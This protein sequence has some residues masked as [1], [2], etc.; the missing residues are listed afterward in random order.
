[1]KPPTIKRASLIL[2]L[3]ALGATTLA[4][5]HPA[6]EDAHAQPA[7]AAPATDPAEQS[8]LQAFY[9]QKPTWTPCGEL[10]CATLTVP[11]DY[12]H[13][14]NGQTFTLPLAK[15]AAADPAQ[16][17][18]SLAFNPGGPGE[19]GV[20]QLKDG[21]LSSFSERTRAR[22]DIVGFDPRGVAG[23]KPA[24]DC[25]S[26]DSPD[27]TDQVQPASDDTSTSVYPTTDAER[28]AALADAA[29]QVAACKTHSGAILEHVGTLDAAR[30]MDVLR[31]ALGDDKLSYLGWSYGTYLGTVYGELF[32][33][34]VRALVLDGAM[35][36]S[37]TW[38]EQTLQQGKAF[39]K[40]VDDY[41]QQCATVV[42]DACPATTP[43][44]I[45]KVIT[46]L[47]ARTSKHP[48]RIK[49]TTQRLD[50]NLLLTA[51]TMSMYSPESQWQDLSEALRAAHNGD[52]T[53]L[54]ELASPGISTQDGNTDAGSDPS[55]PAD[56]QAPN[57]SSAAITAVNCLD[58]PHP[59]DPQPY[60]DLLQRANQ[61][62]GAIG[63][64][65]VL[66]ELTCKEWPAG[67]QQP[68]RVH[69]EG[70]PPVLVVGTTGDPATLYPW[71]QSLAAQLPGGMLLTYKGLGHTAY[72]RSNAC[73]TDAVDAYLTDLKP[74]PNGTTC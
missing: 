56:E 49:G 66:A 30:D 36:P 34:R 50:E 67:Q 31:A 28:S 39:Q 21:A 19:S 59:R 64:T 41:A 46:D 10:Q 47:S 73:V 60:W 72:G 24:I 25:G 69:A 58:Q 57:N 27:T 35:D 26:T 70:L 48:L 22:F 51:I 2:A 54:A 45:R 37:L 74:V 63:T 3:A 5:C 71:A 40:A 6:A 18:G 43:D 4:G 33:H 7:A 53:K 42:H 1:M 55:T 29:R 14:E 15:K 8:T 11:M 20:G 44:G 61:E 52:G 68:H 65:T 32:P 38:S 62:A 13:P 12:A 17:I 16:R 9:Q 23:S